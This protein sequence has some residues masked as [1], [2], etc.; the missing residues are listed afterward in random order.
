MML[1]VTAGRVAHCRFKNHL[2]LVR[3]DRNTA[4]GLDQEASLSSCVGW[5]AYR[6][7]AALAGVSFA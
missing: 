3:G 1:G 4:V 6:A 2:G 5:A 7:A